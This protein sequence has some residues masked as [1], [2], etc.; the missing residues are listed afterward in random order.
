MYDA[1]ASRLTVYVFAHPSQPFDDPGPP[2]Q[3]NEQAGQRTD[4]IYSP[5]RGRH[6]GSSL[7]QDA[8]TITRDARPNTVRVSL[9]PKHQFCMTLANRR[10][11]RSPR[12]FRKAEYNYQQLPQQGQ[13]TG[14]QS[15]SPYSYSTSPRS[16]PSR[17]SSSQASFPIEVYPQTPMPE[18]HFP[19]TGLSPTIQYISMSDIEMQTKQDGMGT[20]IASDVGIRCATFVLACFLMD[21]R[22]ATDCTKRV[23]AISGT[24]EVKD[25]TRVQSTTSMLL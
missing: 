25:V 10:A 17:S 6:G 3:G 5:G 15:R 4:D 1:W 20:N 8:T 13:A 11:Q 21:G 12:T 24:P 16:L 7:P 9:L 23:T 22:N 18:P 2:I 14:D 19:K